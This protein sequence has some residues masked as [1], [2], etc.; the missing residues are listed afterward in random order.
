M[1]QDALNKQ[2]SLFVELDDLCVLGPH[3]LLHIGAWVPLCLQVQETATGQVTVTVI[4]TVTTTDTVTDTVAH[5]GTVHGTASV[6]GT[7]TV[8]GSVSVSSAASTP[9]FKGR[10][11]GLP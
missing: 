11:L 5:T 8:A 9:N 7:V 2:H 10:A 3:L 1:L 4:A 6:A